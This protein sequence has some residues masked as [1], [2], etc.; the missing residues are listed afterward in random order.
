MPQLS[1]CVCVCACIW[2]SMCVCGM[3]VR[4]LNAQHSVECKT[5]RNAQFTFYNTGSLSE[6]QMWIC[7]IRGSQS[8]SQWLLCR[9]TA[10]GENR[11]TWCNAWAASASRSTSKLWG[12]Q[13]SRFPVSSPQRAAPS[14]SRTSR[15]S[16]APLEIL[17]LFL[18]ISMLVR[19]RK[20]KRLW[21]QQKFWF[22][23]KPF[24]INVRR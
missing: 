13:H 14:Q 7:R 10:L 22:L 5:K 18:K 3:T 6:H 15:G 16:W 12:E 17:R 2:A 24:S 8:Q 11:G 21:E 4:L 1:Y 23:I 9:H 20:T 19:I